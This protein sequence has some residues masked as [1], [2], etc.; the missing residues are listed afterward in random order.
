MTYIALAVARSRVRRRE[1]LPTDGLRWKG[2]RLA[3]GWNFERSGAEITLQ[4]EN[5]FLKQVPRERRENVAHD[6]DE[7]KREK[8]V[9]VEVQRLHESE[10]NFV[11]Q[12]E[13]IAD[14]PRVD[15]KA[16]G[17][18]CLEPFL[19]REESDVKQSRRRC[20]GESKNDPLRAQIGGEKRE[21]RC[22]DEQYPES[23]EQFGGSKVDSANKERQERSGHQS[24]EAAE[25]VGVEVHVM[26]RE[27]IAQRR[28]NANLR[29]GQALQRVRG[30]E[31]HNQRPHEIKLL[32][33]RERPGDSERPGGICRNW[34]QKILQ[35]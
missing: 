1:S 28:R 11:Q 21:R 23:S 6:E 34:K 15:Q 13:P 16:I 33:D 32:L 4:V 10:R 9:T 19:R 18:D 31:A 5:R 2:C 7:R 20:S 27:V 17:H 25:H 12:V 26:Q 35:K 24:I 29:D 3:Y 8:R 14:E 22:D 30:A